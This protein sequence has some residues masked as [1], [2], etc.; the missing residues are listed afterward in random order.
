MQFYEKKELAEETWNGSSLTPLL[1]FLASQLRSSSLIEM[2]LTC[3]Q[4]GRSTGMPEESTCSEAWSINRSIRR[5]LVNLRPHA[6]L[7][8]LCTSETSEVLISPSECEITGSQLMAGQTVI[9]FALLSGCFEQQPDV[10]S[11]I[12]GGGRYGCP[13]RAAAARPAGQ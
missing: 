8:Q 12:K 13:L 5:S 2:T 10:T 11:S 1:L 3:Q 9:P 6:D 7:R 4:G